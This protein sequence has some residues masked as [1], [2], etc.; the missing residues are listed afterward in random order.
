MYKVDFFYIN[1]I[2]QET[3]FLESHNFNNYIYIK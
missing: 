1:I 3:K 2:N